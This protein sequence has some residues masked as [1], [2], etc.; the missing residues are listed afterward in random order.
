MVLTR[1]S[2]SMVTRSKTSQLPDGKDSFSELP[3]KRKVS[4]RDSKPKADAKRP[5]RSFHTETQP[6]PAV[7]SPVIESSRPV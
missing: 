4:T 1:T 3:K 5:A 7:P 2:K 6:H